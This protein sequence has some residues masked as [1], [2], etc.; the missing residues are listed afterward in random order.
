M[1][2]VMLVDDESIFIEHLEKIIDWNLHN[3]AICG[4]ASDGVEALELINFE[5]PD[6][7]FVDINMPNMGGLEVCKAVNSME[8]PP[9]MVILTAHNEFNFV[10]KAIN[11]GV[12]AYLL[13][14][15]DK[16][17]LVQA[18]NK[19][20]SDIEKNIEHQILL[21]DKNDDEVERY[22]RN[23]IELGKEASKNQNFEVDNATGFVVSILKLNHDCGFENRDLKKQFF[24]H[25]VST[26]NYL[27]GIY[28][29]MPVFVHSLFEKIDIANFREN[30]KSQLNSFDEVIECASIGSIV[31]KLTL[32]HK[33]YQQAIIGIENRIQIKKRII[34]FQDVGILDDKKQIYTL[35]DVLILI[36]Y[37]EE[38]QYEK[39][40]MIIERIFS[41]CGNKLLSFQYL[42]SIY[43]SLID[44]IYTECKHTEHKL[45]EHMSSQ[46]QI[47]RE[48]NTCDNTQKVT[49]IIKNYV[50]EVLSDCMN[51][52]ISN[53]SSE[54]V[55]KINGYLEKHYIDASL[56][57]AKISHELFFEN[58]YL[59]RVY[60]T[61]TGKT[62]VQQLEDVRITK[63]KELLKQTNAKLSE[64]AHL[65]GF[66]DQFYFSRR[67]KLVTNLSPTEYRAIYEKN[68]NI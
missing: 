53:K 66:S 1:F 32:L 38:R 47:I 18:L 41:L 51:F 48:L 9:R 54:L 62:I 16:D 31:N 22:L 63:A 64:I 25:F 59:R 28:N 6:I 52:N 21:E 40:D 13:K 34:T 14:P 43:F 11:L 24:K 30:Y 55:D 36:K 46:V 29:G 27:I 68:T 20:V 45:I 33:S 23:I 65:T 26:K 58:S 3:C 50:Y 44:S 19:C 42:V 56:T 10:H 15:F 8:K 2:K 5:K 7:V 4:I 61:H 17:E 60:K 12:F 37:F 67:F 49:E 35:S 39:A 57:V